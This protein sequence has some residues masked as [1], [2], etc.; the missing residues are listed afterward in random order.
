[1]QVSTDAS[2]V[3]TVVIDADGSLVNVQPSIIKHKHLFIGGL[4]QRDAVPTMITDMLQQLPF[5]SKVQTEDTKTSV[6]H[7]TTEAATSTVADITTGLKQTPYPQYD[8]VSIL[9][10]H[11]IHIEDV[12]RAVNAARG[13][14][15]SNELKVPLVSSSADTTSVLWSESA[16]SILWPTFIQSAIGPNDIGFLFVLQ[17]PLQWALT[18]NEWI[19][20]S[21]TVRDLI[22][23]WL[24]VHNHMLKDLHSLKAVALVHSEVLLHD[25][26]AISTVIEWLSEMSMLTSEESTEAHNAV[27]ENYADTIVA[28]AQLQT[29]HSNDLL[30]CWIAGGTWITVPASSD[31]YSDSYNTRNSYCR[32]PAKRTAK[33]PSAVV[34]PKHMTAATVVTQ[35]SALQTYFSDAERK[36]YYYNLNDDDN[37]VSIRVSSA[38][39]H[40]F[41]DYIAAYYSADVFLSD[42]LLVLD[43]QSVD[44]VAGSVKAAEVQALHD[45]FEHQVR[46]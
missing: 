9:Q 46:Y 21:I 17:H 43:D 7:D 28:A 5:A 14:L 6:I 11:G 2:R 22:A 39:S 8:P 26:T 30:K 38:M 42:E 41:D 3:G 25:R 24:T 15:L 16:N 12:K 1:L 19:S 37:T 13:K 36:L 32:E 34:V 40:Y 20:D 18:V 29:E 27:A 10:E 33:T 4:Q 44:V 31:S 35:D 45:E 23:L